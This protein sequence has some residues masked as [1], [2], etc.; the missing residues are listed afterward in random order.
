MLLCAALL[1]ATW[2][3]LAAL[4]G[5][6]SQILAGDAYVITQGSG[7]LSINTSLA[8]N[9]TRQ[10]AAGNVSPEVLSL[11]TLRGEPVLIRAVKPDAFFAVEG[12][13]PGPSVTLGD[14]WAL[15]GEGLA[16]RLRLSAGENVTLVGSVLPRIAFAP[17]AGV[18]RTATPANDELLVDYGLG[19]FLAGLGSMSF[20]SIRVKTSDPDALLAFLRG[21][22]AS[23]HVSGPGMPQVDIA[24]SPPTDE[25]VANLILRTGIGGSANDYLTTA[26]GEASA[27]VRVVAYGIAALLALLTAFGIHAVQR[28]AFADRLPVVGVLRAVGAGNRWMRRRFL[29]ESLPLAVAAGVIGAA[30]GL[31]GEARL[32]PNGRLLV[33]GHEVLVTFDPVTFALIVLAIVAMSTL[34]GLGLLQAALRERPSGSIREAPAVEPPRSLEAVLRG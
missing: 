9:L 13:E 30:L 34:S 10:F 26:V 17:I 24:S 4:P 7:P 31:L 1:G 6:P 16:G 14:R 29:A 28:R 23:A 21:F 27:S 15:V 33:F 25:R 22:G 8:E 3:I 2:P 20:H 18:Y 5:I 32:Q 12:A 19:R 11:G